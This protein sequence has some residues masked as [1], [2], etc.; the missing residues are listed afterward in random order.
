MALGVGVYDGFYGPGTGTFLLL[1]LTAAAHLPLATANG[2]AKV[3]N[4][5]TNLTAC[6]SLGSTGQ[7]CCPWGLAAGPAAWWATG[8]GPPSS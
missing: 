7:V 5:T 8:W 2:V 1:L 6:P 4:L 3:L